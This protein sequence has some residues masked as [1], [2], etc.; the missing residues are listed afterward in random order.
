MA[1]YQ[2]KV[3]FEPRGEWVTV[4]D[5]EYIEGYPLICFDSQERLN[6]FAAQV[7]HAYLSKKHTQFSFMVSAHAE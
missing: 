2:V 3:W 7:R 1:Y 5:I 6:Q 4:K